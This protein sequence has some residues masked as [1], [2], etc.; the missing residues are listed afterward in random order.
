MTTRTSRTTIATLTGVYE[1]DGSTLIDFNRASITVKGQTVLLVPRNAR[2]V[3]PL[4]WLPDII[5]DALKSTGWALPPNDQ[6]IPLV[7]PATAFEVVARDLD[8]CLDHANLRSQLEDLRDAG[9]APEVYTQFLA[10]QP[11]KS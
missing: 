2:P 6:A 11:R 7:A 5:N 4:A 1:Q 3:N 9:V 8:W 10:D